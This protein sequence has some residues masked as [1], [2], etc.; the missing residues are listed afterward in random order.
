MFAVLEHFLQEIS[1]RRLFLVVFVL[2]FEVF[3]AVWLEG[4]LPMS[5]A[6]RLVQKLS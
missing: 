1:K 4:S 6:R 5:K 3:Y 2:L